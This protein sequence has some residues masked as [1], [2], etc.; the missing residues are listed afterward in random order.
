M[1]GLRKSCLIYGDVFRYRES[2]EVAGT[3]IG[4]EGVLSRATVILCGIK[5]KCVSQ[6]ILLNEKNREK[7]S[8][9]GHSSD[10]FYVETDL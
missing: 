3:Y 2:F 6:R 9:C 5:L 4:A 1:R 10:N 8:V 7:K